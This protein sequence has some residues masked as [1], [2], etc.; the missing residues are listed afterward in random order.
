MARGVLSQVSCHC[1]YASFPFICCMCLTHIGKLVRSRLGALVYSY[2]LDTFFSGEE[3]AYSQV[4]PVGRSLRSLQPD[5]DAFGASNITQLAGNAVSLP[6]M[7]VVAVAM[8]YNP[9]APW[10]VT[11]PDTE[12]P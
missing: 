3:M 5:M 11:R 10:W 7:S 9:H 1:A 6:V 4:W 8:W 12:L 2:E